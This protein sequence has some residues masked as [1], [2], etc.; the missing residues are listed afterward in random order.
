MRNLRSTS[1]PGLVL[2]RTRFLFYSPGRA[3][4]HLRPLLHVA[5]SESW[6]FAI[7]SGSLRRNSCASVSEMSIGRA[8]EAAPAIRQL[9][10]LQIV[11]GA[12]KRPGRP[13]GWS[14][15]AL[16]LQGWRPSH[17]DPVDRRPSQLSR[18]NAKGIQHAKRWPR[19]TI[20][21]E[22]VFAKKTGSAGLGRAESVRPHCGE[23]GTENRRPCQQPH[24]FPKPICPPPLTRQIGSIT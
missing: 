15:A 10:F 24:R 21:L 22:S 4:R 18:S 6:H 1:S 5:L 12:S 14:P 3:S 7:R 17:Q 20:A 16:S 11:A 8:V 13:A 19:M 2:L 9:D 23:S